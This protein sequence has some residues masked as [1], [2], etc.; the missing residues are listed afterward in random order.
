MLL[1]TRRE[2]ERLRKS[3]EPS[4]VRL[5]F[6]GESPPASGRFFYS[7]NSGLYRAMQAAFELADTRVRGDNFL[8]AF[9][10]YGCYLIDVSRDPVDHLDGPT[11]RTICKTGE[12]YL[13]K[14]IRRL[15]PE[16]I[17][18]VLRSVASNVERAAGRANWEGRLLPLPYPGRWS[19]FREA[20]IRILV[21]VLRQLRLEKDGELPDHSK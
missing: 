12:E 2:R 6:V 10:A 18:P 15:Q 4:R 1:T 17:A 21:P 9:R 8:P 13:T 3:F 7:G 20:F 19:R 11:R 5:L 16:I 14:E